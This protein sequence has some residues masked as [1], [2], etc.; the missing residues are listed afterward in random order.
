MGKVELYQTFFSS[1]DALS[2][3]NELKQQW[4]I[5][6]NDAFHTL[7]NLH[8]NFI[9]LIMKKKKSPNSTHTM[10]WHTNVFS[11]LQKMHIKLSI[12]LDLLPLEL[13]SIFNLSHFKLMLIIYCTFKLMLVVCHTFKFV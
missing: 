6:A 3:V 8:I 7:H 2:T 4:I 13:H 5:I 11:L 9:V 1:R 12:M 10:K